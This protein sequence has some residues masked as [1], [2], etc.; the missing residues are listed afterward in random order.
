MVLGARGIGLGDRQQAHGLSLRKPLWEGVPS[1]LD[2][3]RKHRRSSDPVQSS[4][5][6]GGLVNPPT[7][8]GRSWVGG[9]LCSLSSLSAATQSG[10]GRCQRMFLNTSPTCTLSPEDKEPAPKDP[11]D[12]GPAP[13]HLSL[14]RGWRNIPPLLEHIGDVRVSSK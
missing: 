5:Q 1:I 7:R 13:S 9:S 2:L 12:V 11:A 8:C 10:S 3:I 4:G 14:Q 6:G